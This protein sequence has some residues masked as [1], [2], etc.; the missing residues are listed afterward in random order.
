MS[1]ENYGNLAGA[2]IDLATMGEGYCHGCA[3]GSSFNYYGLDN[4]YGSHILERYCAGCAE[5]GYYNYYQL[6]NAYQPHILRR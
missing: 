3:S 1:A 2:Y 4:A 6:D 5:G